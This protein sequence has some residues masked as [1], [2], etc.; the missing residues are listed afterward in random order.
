MSRKRILSALLAMLLTAC[1]YFTV[2]GASINIAETGAVQETAEVGASVELA[3]IGT[4]NI[5]GLCDNIQEGQILQC[6]GWSFDNIKANLQKIAEQGFTA[7]QTSPIQSSKESTKEYYS[8]FYN[9]SWVYYQPLTFS[10]ETNSYN[11]LGTKSQFVSMCE[12][13]EKYGIKVIVDAV[14][15]HMAND[16]SENTIHPYI[17]SEIKNNS[18][19]WHDISKNCSNYS[20]RYDI[21]HYCLS[22]LP[23]LNSSN[24]IV[25]EHCTNFLKECIDA[26]ADGFRFDAAKHIETP[27]DAS[28]T[29]SDFWPNVLNA[30][31]EYAQSTYGTTPYYYG[32]LLDDPGDGNIGAYTQYMS[33]TDN[34]SSNSIRQA[35]CDG[36]ASGAANPGIFN[37]ASPSK[38]VQWTESHDTYKDAGTRYISNENINKTWAIV[39]SRAEVCGQYLAR[40]SDIET[41]MLGS[42]DVT[43]WSSAS[44]KAVNQF[45]NHFVGQSEYFSSY[46]SL[47][48]VERGTSGMII[49]NVGGT[50]FDGMSAPVHTMATGTYTDAL[51]G[52]TF[53]VK[54]GYISG[55]IGDRGIAVVYNADEMGT[56][57]EGYVTDLSV[58]GT[59][60]NW[61]TDANKMVA[62]SANTATTTMFLDAGTY[63][64]KITT[65]DIW[66][67]N[68]GTMED[69]TTASSS[70]GWTFSSSVTDNCTL[71]ASGGKYTFT[72]DIS[73]GKLVV[74]HE[75]TTDKTSSLYLKG[76]FN[77]WDSSAPMIYEDGTNSVSAT[78]ELDAG[79]YTF[80]LHNTDGDV[81]Y[82]KDNTIDDETTSSSSVG[83]TFYPDQ[84][85]CTLN[86]TGGTYKFTFNLS[87]QKLT[88]EYNAG[89]ETET[90]TPSD[91]TPVTTVYTV[92]FADYDGTVLSTE[93]V[94]KGK[95]ATAPADPVRAAD[96]QYTYTFSGWDKDFSNITEDITVTATYSKVTN[97]YTVTFCDYDGEVLDTQ[98]VE[99]GTAATAPADPVR[100]G[101][102]FTGWDVA[103]D[104]ITEDTTVTATYSDASVYLKG[105]FN[106]WGSDMPFELV[107]GTSY[108]QTIE[109]E[110]GTYTFKIYYNEKWYGNTGT[111]NDTTT[112]SSNSG[113]TMS[114]SKDKCT[115]VA[116]GGTYTFNYDTSTNKL[117][118]LYAAPEYTVTFV[119]YDGEVLDTQTVTKGESATAPAEPSR[120]NTAQYSYTFLGWDK[121]FSNITE[122]TTVTALYTETIN[123]YTVTFKDYNGDVLDTQ[124]VEYG[125]SATAPQTPVRTGYTFS[126]WNKS[127]D[128]ITS[129]LT[130]TAVYT[131][132]EATLT[133][134]VLKVDI[135]GGSGFTVSVNG[136]NARPQGLSY[137]NTQMPIAAT[138]TVV[139][140]STNGNEFI[141]W[142]N[143]TTGAIVSTSETYTFATSGNDFI[144]AMYSTEV[145]GVNL[146]TFK[147]DRAAGGLGQILDMQYY[148]ADDEIVFPADPTLTGYDFAGWNMTAEEIAA[149]L[150]AGKDVVVLPTWTAKIVYVKVSVNG[151]QITN[152]LTDGN[153]G[154]LY[155]R[156][157]TVVA[158]AAESGKKFAY[159]ADQNGNVRSYQSTYTFNAYFDVELTAVY[160]D[161]AAEIDYEVIVGI[162]AD[163]TADTIKIGYSLFWEVP[164]ELGTFVQGGI[165]I[166]E[167]KNYNE[168]NFVVGGNAQDTN[169]TQ[170]APGAAQS[171]PQPGY[172]V[173]KTN[174]FIG[175]SWY[176]KAFVQYRDANGDIQT[177]Y[178]DMVAVDKI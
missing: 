167:Q 90:T 131:K 96:A 50:Y 125:K 47:A 101:Y 23:D 163:P 6:W 153:G 148:A 68:A 13:A 168:A 80:K 9:S 87:T 136:G 110:A 102:T 86:A 134:G 63:T 117:K 10:I 16:M 169:I 105:T 60:N 95:S 135:I 27:S 123:K 20:D 44:V 82:G 147:N 91:T 132:N 2:A 166:V 129:D 99:Y 35:I 146:V 22:G 171:N 130:V 11:A 126:N 45:K 3:E 140:S 111:I 67:G 74:E 145:A 15:N 32:E 51:T 124:S 77:N 79:S 75:D 12:E 100:D 118:V 116:S 157:V 155:N 26:G 161:E 65:G 112:T 71:V 108:T 73:T 106:N 30:A 98:S 24:S 7:I 165:L 8:T 72:F 57:T 18:D 39:G 5:Y 107:S 138:V 37:G 70:S 158:D 21:T 137:M 38:T 81:W 174:S 128:S 52:N 94:E 85:K 29:K 143:A 159:W 42:A 151:G 127:F 33:V 119:D 76:T 122:D 78:L 177:A 25:Q 55:D 113:W 41:T 4:S 61:D 19:C 176:A 28:G 97:K 139:A 53:T 144:K 84:G 43:S 115:L 141:G 58:A 133:N 1:S 36:N 152:G 156:S 46:N 121:D 54:D 88:V 64:F 62:D 173:N 109:L 49:V 17:T 103:F 56:L 172:T 89:E 154:Y 14:F 164:E 142:M 170:A 175:T 150:A 83:W 162:S 40:P 69:S 178:S 104:N 59:F 92:T 160:V 149:E 31:T 48:C 66:Y 93:S 34:Q 114:T 120:E